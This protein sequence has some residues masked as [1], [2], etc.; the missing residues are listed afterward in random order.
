MIQSFT[1]PQAGP[2]LSCPLAWRSQAQDQTCS[3]RSSCTI[4]CTM[5]TSTHSPL[6]PAHLVPLPANLLDYAGDLPAISRTTAGFGV[7]FFNLMSLSFSFPGLPG[8]LI[9]K[10][11]YQDASTTLSLC[12]LIP[13]SRVSVFILDRITFGLVAFLCTACSTDF[14]GV[15]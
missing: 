8:M 3:A 10:K 4:L 9:V 7:P 6:L 5:Q 1:F 2:L 13:D 15:S 11:L 12:I 14:E